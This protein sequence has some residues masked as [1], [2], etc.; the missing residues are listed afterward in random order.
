[1]SI[2]GMQELIPAGRVVVVIDVIRAF[3]TAAIAF[4]RGVTDIACAPT[5]EAGREL[6]R[7]YPERLLA[8]EIRG[9]KPADF[10]IGNS[11]Y[12]MSTAPVH[13]RRLIQTTSNGTRGLTRC[14]DPVA[15]LAA[16]AR[17]VGATARWIASNHPGTP[18][19]L[20]CTGRTA[21]DRACAEHLDALLRGS[22]PRAAD[23]VDG[24]RAGAA[25]LARSFARR[26]VSEV[27]DL[28]PDLGF[29]SE[30]D[31]SDFAMVGYIREGHV[32][33]TAVRS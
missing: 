2:I 1:M 13:G 14:P 28:S 26:P 10:D 3:T 32:E 19:T 12:E 21:E 16:S 33:L 18:W 9:L 23:L 31:R 17:N 27:V 11:P 22:V 20:L 29:C 7:R 8:G 4:E 6:R 5:P 25:E 15:L 24:I 30:V